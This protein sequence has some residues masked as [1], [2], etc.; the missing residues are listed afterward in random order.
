[1]GHNIHFRFCIKLRNYPKLIRLP[2]KRLLSFI[3]IE[4]LH[5]HEIVNYK[6]P[7]DMSLDP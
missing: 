4:V 3:L 2:I 1:M 6:R 7:L 5:D